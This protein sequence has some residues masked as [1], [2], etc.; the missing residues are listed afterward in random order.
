MKNTIL[1]F[2]CAFALL[3]GDPSRAAAPETL[4]EPPPVSN[5]APTG[6]SAPPAAAV[7]AEMTDWQARLELARLLTY[8]QRYQEAIGEY[9]KVLVVK[10]E[11]AEARLGLAQA[12][13]WSGDQE[14]AAA[15]MA[16]IPP[17]ELEEQDRLFLADI[18]VTRQQYPEAIKIYA[19]Y[20]RQNPADQQ[21]RLQKAQTLA[22][23][24]RYPEAI[25][26]FEQLVAA[27]PNDRQLK[28]RFAEVLTW[29]GEN[30]RAI[31][32]LQQ[33]LGE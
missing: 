31:E 1:L 15:A 20:L 2:C 13:Y 11:L 27:R 32:L 22:W 5:P 8:R 28:R 24:Q 4:S 10:P 23:A 19:Q 7:E 25:G 12:L 14:G 26:Q 16:K 30:D 29:A 9:R 17:E 33:S 21:V 18:L 3:V 6:P